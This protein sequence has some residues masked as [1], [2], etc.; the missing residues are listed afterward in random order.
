M[1]TIFQIDDTTECFR[2]IFYHKG[3]SEEPAAFKGFTYKHDMHV[4]IYGSI[5]VFKEEKAI[6]GSFIKSLKLQD[7]MTN[8]FLQVFVSHSIRHKGLLSNNVLKA[9]DSNA[10]DTAGMNIPQRGQKVGNFKDM[11]LDLIKE[12]QKNSSSRFTHRNDLWTICQ[13]KM[14]NG[15]FSSAIQDLLDDGAIYTTV[16]NDCFSVTD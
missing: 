13:S 11:V 2:V 15:E 7:E 1:R 5:R 10:A 8:H 3:E 16:D 4:K 12:V 14:Q 9:Q 6:V